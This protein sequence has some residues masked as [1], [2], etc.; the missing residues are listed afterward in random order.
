MVPTSLTQKGSKARRIHGGHLP[1][2]SVVS[3]KV[4][5]LMLANFG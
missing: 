5:H 4:S 3:W 1:L 2:L